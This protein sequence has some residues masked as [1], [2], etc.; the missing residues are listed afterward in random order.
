MSVNT[1][2]VSLFRRF[3]ENLIEALDITPT[4][5]LGNSPDIEL[6]ERDLVTLS[7]NIRNWMCVWEFFKNSVFDFEQIFE[8][9]WPEII[10]ALFII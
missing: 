8:A 10:P 2:L 5:I 9:Q 4:N 3:L 7:V 6:S 1:D